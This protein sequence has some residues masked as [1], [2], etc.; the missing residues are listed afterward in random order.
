MRFVELFGKA[1]FVSLVLLS[2]FSL[3]S[4]AED[5]GG[6]STGSSAEVC[7]IDAYGKETC[8]PPSQVAVVGNN[9]ALR[10]DF[11][12]GPN[13][14][15]FTDVT[16]SQTQKI[17]PV[18]KVNIVSYGDLESYNTKVVDSI[19]TRLKSEYGDVISIQFKHVTW[20]DI[21]LNNWD[22]AEAAECARDQGKFEE[23]KQ[24]IFDTLG[25]VQNDSL[26]EKDAYEIGLDVS[27]FGQ[28]VS[29]HAKKAVIEQDNADAKAAGALILPYTV[30]E[31][32]PM[33]GAYYYDQFKAVVAGFL[34]GQID[35][36]IYT[37]ELPDPA[38]FEGKPVPQSKYIHYLDPAVGTAADYYEGKTDPMFHL[39]IVGWINHGE[40]DHAPYQPYPPRFMGNVWDGWFNQNQFGAVL[41]SID[42][43]NHLLYISLPASKVN[44]A[45]RFWGINTYFDDRYPRPE[46]P[47][48]IP[49]PWPSPTPTPS[50]SPSPIPTPGPTI[51]PTSTPL[52]A[53]TDIPAET[54]Q[55][56]IASNSIVVKISQ[57]GGKA[58]ATISSQTGN[59]VISSQGVSA[60]VSN[61]TKLGF[62]D[63]GIEIEGKPVKLLPNQALAV[64]S[65]SP[66]AL[67][68]QSIELK[69]QLFQP[70]YEVDA[71]KKAKLFGVFEVT[72][73]VNAVIDA[74]DGSVKSVEKPAW[75]FLVGE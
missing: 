11:A 26:F 72:Y 39:K 5:A 8:V 23:F 37:K 24:K 3:F 12:A 1:F 44:A 32:K 31:G 10:R 14:G 46:V 28:C 62:G 59:M 48:P 15:K 55:T 53:A 49:Y 50:A 71:V 9:F 74:Q 2:L 25:E 69:T 47:A 35:Y 64:I 33:Y 56:P 58:S 19:L 6:I 61:E 13:S 30:I 57:D 75:G 45:S 40:L 67:K 52:P 43:D 21:A 51:A 66:A 22:V 36:Q 68:E 29:S 27:T 38:L 34:G 54:T 63:G 7:F 65:P 20:P 70:V 42:E 73:P 60:V 4:Y 17:A 16:A 41:E 18:K